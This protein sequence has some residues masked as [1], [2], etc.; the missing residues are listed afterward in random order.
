MPV[1]PPRAFTSGLPTPGK[2]ARRTRRAEPGLVAGAEIK[3][4]LAGSRGFAVLRHSSKIINAPA[5]KRTKQALG[6]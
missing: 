2:D 5:T 3:N 1:W 6:C 4:F